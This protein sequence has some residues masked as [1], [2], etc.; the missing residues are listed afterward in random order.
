MGEGKNK[1]QA[2]KKKDIVYIADHMNGC[3]GLFY[4]V[5]HKPFVKVSSKNG[6][7]FKI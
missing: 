5:L 2:C 1:N 6:I 4:K 3:D 7:N